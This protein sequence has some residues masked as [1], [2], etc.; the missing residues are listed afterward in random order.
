MKSVI[1]NGSYEL[2]E[3]GRWFSHKSQK[4]LKPNINSSGYERA[5]LRINGVR[6]M[7]FIHIKVVEFFG[8]CKGNKIPPNN[9]SLIEL[10]LSIDHID[11]NKHNNARTN[12]ELVTHKENCYRRDHKGVNYDLQRETKQA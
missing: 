3:N 1:I 5:D 11:R 4:W 6:K 8:D 12:L 7:L 9:G 10:G 2:F